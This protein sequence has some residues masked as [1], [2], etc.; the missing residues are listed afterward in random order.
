MCVVVSLS[1]LALRPEAGNSRRTH[2]PP[3]PGGTAIHK[4]HWLIVHRIRHL[5]HGLDSVTMIFNGANAE[6]EEF[7]V[8]VGLTITAM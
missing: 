5:P 8:A 4:S 2:Q 7:Q 3:E 1:H 6:V